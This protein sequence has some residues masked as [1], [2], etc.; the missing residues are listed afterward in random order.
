MEEKTEAKKDVVERKKR[1]WGT[2]LAIIMGI[3]FISVA[4]FCAYLLGQ[5]QALKNAQKMAQIVSAPTIPAP[6]LPPS[7]KASLSPTVQPVTIQIDEEPNLPA[8]DVSEIKNRNI[9]PFVDWSA[10]QNSGGGLIL[11]KV[12]VNNDPAYPYKFEYVYKNGGDGG[13]LIKRTDG[14]L[15]WYM[16]DCLGD[17]NFTS[18]FKQNY[19]EIV[20]KY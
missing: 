19:P 6:I 18:R 20:S 1:P 17:C 8:Q 13:F 5:N 11:I 15:D 12:T 7:D 3:V 9:N 14:H 16:P 10:D 2:L 4:S